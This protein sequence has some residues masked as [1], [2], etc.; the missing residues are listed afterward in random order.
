MVGCVV[1]RNGRAVGEAFHRRAG[2]PH[3]EIEALRRAGAHAKGATLY[4]TLEPC[5]HQGRTPACA[6]RVAQAGIVRVVA[7]VRDPNPLVSGR[8]LSALRRAGVD[9]LVGVGAAE[10]RRLNRR[11]LAGVAGRRPFVTLK[12]AMT[13]DGRIATSAGESKWITSARARRSARALR[14]SHDAV[15]VGIE[16][17]L[18]DDPL[19]LPSPKVRRPFVRVVLDSRLR[20][21]VGSRLAKSARAHPVWVFC[22]SRAKRSARRRLEK[23]GIEVHP[24]RSRDGR[25]D[26][27]AALRRL[28][29]RG[30]LS[31]M[32]EG[33][34]EVLGSFLA[35]RFLDEVVIFRAPILLGGRGSRPAF[36]GFDP[37]HLGDAVRLNPAPYR[38]KDAEAWTPLRP[39]GR[40]RGFSR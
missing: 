13:L 5:A 35:H 9:V 38:V 6:P 14:R 36:G 37:A 11:F 31:L 40:A 18:A 21:P 22:G 7:A 28:R 25:V 23:L 16:T 3:A 10:A 17:A 12:V 24:I 19:L 33:G 20:L 4:V 1:V 30:V 2:E 27:G 34:G 26:L 39:L 8:G 15:L 32:V 29:S